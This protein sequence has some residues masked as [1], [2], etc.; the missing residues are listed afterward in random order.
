MHIFKLPSP[1][2]KDQQYC[3]R[4][5]TARA[6]LP[7]LLGLTRLED[8]GTRACELHNGTRTRDMSAEEKWPE[9]WSKEAALWITAGCIQSQNTKDQIILW[10]FGT[11]TYSP[12][13]TYAIFCNRSIDILIILPLKLFIK[14]PIINLS[15][16]HC[17]W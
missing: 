11:R 3:T 13:L 12:K 15:R 9:P 2:T 1:L 8:G 4:L 17:Q 5:K 16:L 14:E 7:K 10:S 6:V